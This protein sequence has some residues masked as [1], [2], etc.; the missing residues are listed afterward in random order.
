MS[1]NLLIVSHGLTGHRLQWLQ[2]LSIIAGDMNVRVSIVLCEQID[3]EIQ[4]FLVRTNIEVNVFYVYCKREL[5]KFAQ[6]YNERHPDSRIVVWDAEEFL[7][8]L[9]RAQFPVKALFLRPYLQEYSFKGI[10]RF[11]FK[12][13][14]MIYLRKA[15]FISVAELRVPFSINY[16][17]GNAYVFDD[18]SILP[19]YP[20]LPIP[21]NEK[22]DLLVVAGFISHRKNIYK[23]LSIFDQL[24]QNPQFQNLKLAIIGKSNLDIHSFK[25]YNAK[26]YI[27]L[28][29]RY[30]DNSDFFAWI[31]RAKT[32]LLIYGNRG[33]SGIVVQSLL[34][35]TKVVFNGASEW[36]ELARLVAPSLVRVPPRSM[37]LVEAISN[38]LS[39]GNLSESQNILK[40]QIDKIPKENLLSSFFLR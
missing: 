33:A 1:Q 31:E 8:S 10:L 30:L 22:E 27:L 9:L 15:K 16:S 17:N 25:P 34:L 5:F 7:F 21:N 24:K 37:D 20:R 13:S 39:G 18:L 40:D 38:T 6:I 19:L 29:N 23:V 3:R 12:R 36:E 26:D 11:V 2:S 4:E 28:E 14:I 35:N 32:I